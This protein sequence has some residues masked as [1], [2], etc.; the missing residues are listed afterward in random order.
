MYLYE[1]RLRFS[2]NIIMQKCL[3][4]SKIQYIEYLRAILY[5]NKNCRAYFGGVRTCSISTTSLLSIENINLL[6]NR[7]PEILRRKEF[8]NVSFHLTFKISYILWHFE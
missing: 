5:A 1:K 4:M 7:C 8:M 3:K 2:S 6:V